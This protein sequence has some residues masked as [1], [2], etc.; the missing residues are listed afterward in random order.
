MG[1]FGLPGLALVA[2]LDLLVLRNAW[3]LSWHLQA[4]DP[5]TQKRHEAE[6]VEHALVQKLVHV[7]IH[8]FEHLSA[9][10]HIHRTKVKPTDYETH[11]CF[12][13]TC[14]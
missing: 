13:R 14:L 8:P 11:S 7:V 3:N 1:S 4:G 10:G 2:H 9:V 6:K 5:V 12:E